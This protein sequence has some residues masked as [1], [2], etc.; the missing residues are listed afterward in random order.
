MSGN[1]REMITMAKWPFPV[2]IRLGIPP[3]GLGQRYSGLLGSTKIAA[4]A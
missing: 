1:P 2:R 3:D 4:S